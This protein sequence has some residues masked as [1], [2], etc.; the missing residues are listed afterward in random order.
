MTHILTQAQRDARAFA[1][2]RYANAQ[3]WDCSYDEI[4]DATGLTHNQVKE[5]FR[6]ENWF[7][8]IGSGSRGGAIGGGRSSKAHRTKGHRFDENALDLCELIGAY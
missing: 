4:A 6:R 5:T 7:G 8:R 2:W 1:V 3:D